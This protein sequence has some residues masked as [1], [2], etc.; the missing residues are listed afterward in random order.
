M[1]SETDNWI[2][3]DV[4]SVFAKALT[5]ATIYAVGVL[6]L[7]LIPFIA[8]LG[9]AHVAYSTIGLSGEWLLLANVVGL[10]VGVVFDLV[11]LGV[12]DEEIDD[13]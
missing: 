1:G 6:I 11:F 9:L 13:D 5:E 4:V 2:D 10:I 7:L 12:I 3:N 8:S